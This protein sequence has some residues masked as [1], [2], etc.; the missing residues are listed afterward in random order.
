MGRLRSP[1]Y[2]KSYPELA[3]EFARRTDNELPKNWSQTV[4][5]AAIAA[6]TKAESVAT[7]KASQIALE[8]FTKELPEMLGG[9]ADLTGSTL[10]Q[11]HELQ[12]RSA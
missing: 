8:A 5:D 12:R 2:A 6:Q 4:V 3:V 7:R 1:S 11:H 9:S 10:D